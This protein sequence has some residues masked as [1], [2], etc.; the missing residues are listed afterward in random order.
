MLQRDRAY[1]QNETGGSY[2]VGRYDNDSLNVEFFEQLVLQSSI[3]TAEELARHVAKEG[4]ILEVGTREGL[5]GDYL[6]RLGYWN[7]EGVDTSISMID[8]ARSRNVY[9][10]LMEAS[11]SDKLDF[12]DNNFDA[13]ICASGLL[14][15]DYGSNLLE[16]MA[17][18]TKREGV[19]IF[20]TLPEHY[21]DERLKTKLSNIQEDGH[22]QLARITDGFILQ[23]S[24]ERD[25]LGQIWVYGIASS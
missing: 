7:I 22:W 23:N 16:E 4:K 6:T 17:R 12:P 21:L 18:V 11:S 24:S 25:V 9:G 14:T 20:A 5:C 3:A 1:G 2:T 19:V 8:Q 10:K 15:G 13:V